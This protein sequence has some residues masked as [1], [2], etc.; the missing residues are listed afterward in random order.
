MPK[1][2]RAIYFEISSRYEL[3]NHVMT[4]GQDILW[5]RKTARIAA[6]G[7]GTV[8]IDIC[9]GT[10]ELAA[11][12]RRLADKTTTIAA[13]DLSF[14][15]AEAGSLPFRDS[16]FD[17]VTTSFA[18]RNIS[19]NR[20]VLTRCFRE[21]HRILKTG[22]R[23]VSVETSQP[24][25]NCARTLYHLYVGLAVRPIGTLVSGSGGS[26]AYLSQTIARF[27]SAD[28]LVR[29]LREAGFA[30]AEFHR[31]LLGVVAIHEATK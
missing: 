16:T 11:Y 10:G 2:L 21:F 1:G 5:R 9:S 24:P 13:A 30:K 8:W 27:Y 3:A 15:L 29:I 12:L 28:E 14:L 19:V 7:G 6:K 31:V 25:S 4:C 26:Y 17:L 23:F 22:G 20:D 18:T